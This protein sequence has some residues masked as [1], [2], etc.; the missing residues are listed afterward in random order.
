MENI[1][2]N[3]FAKLNPKLAEHSQT[4]GSSTTTASNHGSSQ[5]KQ[6][7]AQKNRG[8]YVGASSSMM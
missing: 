7:S 5:Q 2:V 1:N 8:S 6:N 3:K 4:S